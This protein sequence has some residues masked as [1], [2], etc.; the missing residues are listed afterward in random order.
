MGHPTSISVS[1]DDTEYSRYED[2]HRTITATVVVTGGAPY[3]TET[4][5]V[6]LRKARRSRDAVVATQTVSIASATD[7]VTQVVTFDLVD[8]VDSDLINLVRHGKY[9]VHAEYVATAVTGASADFDVRIITI[10]KLKRD[11]LFGL[12]LRATELKQ[13]RYQPVSITGIRISEVS[14]GQPEGFGALS[15]HYHVDGATTVRTLSFN[16]GPSVSITTAG[17]YLLQSGTSSPV[18]LPLV[19][20]NANPQYIEVKVQSTALLPTASVA[21]SVLIERTRMD[22][23]A[24]AGFIDSATKWLEEDELAC[25]VEPTNVVSEVDPTTIQYSTGISNPAPITT[26]ADYDFLK[27]PLTYFIPAGGYSGW[28]WIQTPFMSI[29]RVDTLYGAIAGTRVIDVDLEWIQHSTEGGFIQLIPF[30]TEIAFDFLGLMTVNAIHGAS[31]LPNFWRYNMIV[32]L[33]D[34]SADIRNI[35]AKKAAI[36]ALTLAGQA[37]RPGVGSLS[38]GRDGV[39]QSVSFTAQQQ[40]GMFNAAIQR[41]NDEIKDTMPK[42]RARYR[43]VSLVVV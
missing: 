22:D 20:P 1:V 40:Y 23:K 24:I 7:P 38:L 9:F 17:T 41:Y 18:G 5:V 31:E 30:N 19:I 27:T 34:A 37:I 42:L 8:V 10:E 35:I 6:S 39:S 21:E 26:D 2:D 16:G 28:V 25:Y 43:G 12:D 14:K 33:R 15:Y 29:L 11:F 13:L 36:D 3:T 32:G 4:V